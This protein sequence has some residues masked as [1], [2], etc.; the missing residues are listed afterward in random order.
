MDTALAPF[1]RIILRAILNDVSPIVAR[2]IAV[3]D[4]LEI[5]DLH[6]AFLSIFGW[7]YAP[8]F[9]IRIHAQEYNT[10]PE[11]VRPPTFF[12]LSTTEDLDSGCTLEYRLI[13]TRFTKTFP[14]TTTSQK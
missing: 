8:G 2:V 1:K 4:D 13:H 6:E 7:T 14:S 5:S 10:F 3:P 12:I 11:P 9:I